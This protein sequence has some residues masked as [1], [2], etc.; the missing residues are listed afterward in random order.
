MIYVHWLPI[1]YT[2]YY[3]SFVELRLYIY[4]S[5]YARSCKI[6]TKKTHSFKY[7]IL[8]SGFALKS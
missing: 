2:K 1:K 4:T 7:D 6:N 3:S 5:V 8:C